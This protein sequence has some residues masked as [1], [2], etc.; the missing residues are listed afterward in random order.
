MSRLI[1]A[2]CLVLVAAC[3]SGERFRDT[4]VPMRTVA[5]V[6]LARY[7]GRWHEIARF[8]VFFQEGCTDVTA[9]Y[10]LRADGRVDVLNAC[11]RDGE[12][13]EARAVAR[14]VDG[15]NARLK[16]RFLR[17]LPFEG[18]YW[19]VFLDEGYETAV[20]GVPSGSAGWILARTPEIAPERL[21]T[22][23]AALA[24]NGYDLTRLT[25]TPSR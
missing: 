6:D 18:D 15:S 16:V 21:E 11:V 13:T 19:I 4:S 14:S 25:M 23:R 1:A 5:E 10:A 20:V 9:D 12:R 3:A 8:P 22:A 7:M 2:L 17:V 24:A